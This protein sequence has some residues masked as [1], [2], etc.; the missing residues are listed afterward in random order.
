VTTTSGTRQLLPLVHAARRSSMT[1]RWKCAD[2]CSE[3]VANASENEYFGDVVG[4]AVSRRAV[5]QAGGASAA[6]A[7][8]AAE[9]AAPA[10]AA[11]G[12]AE[13]AVAGRRGTFGFRPIAP[14]PDTE[15]S[16]DVP[17]GFDWAPIISWGDPLL[18]GAPEFDF[19]QQSAEAQA[20]QFGYN[21][22]YTTLLPRG[23]NRGLLVCNHE[24]TNDELMFRGF[25]TAAAETDEQLRISQAAHGMSVVQLRR[26]DRRSPWRY[27]PGA[28]LNRR[29]TAHTRMQFTGPAAGSA[30][31]RTGADPAGRT[32]LGTLN[33]CAGGTTPW[34]TVLTGE[35]NI[36]QYFLNTTPP[37]DQDEA[38]RRYGVA[39]SKGRGWERVDARFDTAKEPN[40]PNRF[41]WVVQLDPTDPTS[42][43]R[44]LT[45]LGRMKHEGATTAL[46]RDGRVAVYLGD[47]ERFEY[48]YKFVSRRRV[49]AG[50]SAAARRHNIRLLDEG[51]LYVGRFVGDGEGDGVHDGRGEWLPLVLGGFS[52]VPGMTVEQVLVWTRIAADKVGATKMDRPEDVETN[53]VTGSVYFM[54]TN[55][56]RRTPA[57]VDEANPRPTNLHGHVLELF[58]R[59]G[60]HG[61]RFFRWDLVL[62]AGDPQDPSTYFAGFDRS[63][64]SSISCPDNVTFDVAGNVWISTDGNKLGH[65]D[66]LFAMPVQGGER[67]H[68][69]RFLSVPTGAEACGPVIARDGRSV[70]VAVQHPGEIEGASAAAP[71]S[72]FPYR[73]DGQPRPSVVQVWRRDGGLIVLR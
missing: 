64:V 50:G 20:S 44:K 38:Y 46:T 24:Y 19:D 32:P 55:N 69:Q 43:P 58:P 56:D 36:N 12:G 7:L 30:L 18:A 42:T 9:G 33:N 67:G 27:V 14:R 71:A 31:L 60:N 70:L 40:E 1:C 48:T 54:L 8:A 72:Q 4:R 45:A 66:G 6:L 61:S 53:P 63:R 62:V 13:R 41:G 2:A 3:P 21:N 34:G 28:P 10:V 68:V 47:D 37:P 29:I 17:P 52:Q 49:R 25:T 73:G 15:D 22:D 39:R 11:A 16:F 57:Q 59:R 51:D 26:R 5:L 65:N 35:E 23:R